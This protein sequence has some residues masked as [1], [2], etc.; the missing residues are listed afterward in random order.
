MS[1]VATPQAVHIRSLSP[2]YGSVMPRTD[3][4][5]WYSVLSV[6]CQL[7]VVLHGHIGRF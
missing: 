1:P 7:V 5:L 6:G 4:V 2:V 3:V